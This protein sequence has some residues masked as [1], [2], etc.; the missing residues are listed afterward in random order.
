MALW[1]NSSPLQR[2]FRS[3]PAR[4]AL[5]RRL[6]ERQEALSRA[7]EQ[8][9]SLLREMEHNGESGRSEYERYYQAYLQARQA[10]KDVDLQLFNYRR[11]LCE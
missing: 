10:Q 6:R 11:G 8:W 5:E 1:Q 9:F 4:A 3:R 7:T 2:L